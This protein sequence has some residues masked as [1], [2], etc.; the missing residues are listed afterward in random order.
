LG[1]GF[2]GV[3]FLLN[4]NFLGLGDGLLVEDGIIPLGLMLIEREDLLG[5]GSLLRE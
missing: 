2:N 3:L 1:Q 4:F 5:W